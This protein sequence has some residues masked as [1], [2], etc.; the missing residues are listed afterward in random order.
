VNF[1]GPAWK[2]AERARRAAWTAGWRWKAWR[3]HVA[4]D[5]AMVRA[6]ASTTSRHPLVRALVALRAARAASADPEAPRWALAELPIALQAGAYERAAELAT[7]LAARISA[8]PEAERR[9][10]ARLI[11]DVRRARGEATSMEA[12]PPDEVR[13]LEILRDPELYLRDVEH[14]ALDPA[15]ASAAL[16]RY[17]RA[18]GMPGATITGAG[19]ALLPRIR[20][21]P[22]PAVTGGPRVS[23]IVA[24]HRAAATIGYALDSLV[25]QSYRNVEI[26]VGIDGDDDGSGE[27]ARA[28]AARD[29]RV[30]V[31]ASARNQGAYN[32]RNALVERSSGHLVT[33][34]DADDLALPTRIAEQ[35]ARIRAGAIACYGSF[36]R[37][38]RAGRFATFA[39]Q[40]ALRLCMVTLML[41]R[42]TFDA[43]GGFRPAWFGADLE[44]RERLRDRHGDGAVE[45]LRRPALFGLWSDA[46]QTRRAGAEAHAD[47]YRAP[48]RR[49][50]TEVVF[51][52]LLGEASDDDIVATLRATDNLASP[53]AISTAAA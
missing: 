11:D 27:L 33:F 53:A 34:H 9:R 41:E 28:A 22:P 42:R 12:S 44:L 48:A 19:D 38:S 35:V 17:L 49:A 15:T 32:L 24:A 30:K 14:H 43:F 40:S 4:L 20:F 3:D 26:L 10:A 2:A 31:F 18:Y 29:P 47:G 36:V 6:G 50:Y 45:V 8:L 46:S 39:G 52:R 21:V 16:T 5:R 1:D 25:G 7:L 13:P 37:V 23:I 51:R